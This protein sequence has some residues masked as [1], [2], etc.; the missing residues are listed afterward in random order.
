MNKLLFFEDLLFKIKNPYALIFKKLPR[1]IQQII[2]K[3]IRD[4][5]VK[6]YTMYNKYNLNKEVICNIPKLDVYCGI[7]FNGGWEYLYHKKHWNLNIKDAFFYYH[8]NK[9]YGITILNNLRNKYKN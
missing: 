5:L 9:Q 1:E 3:N 4:T 8:N 7:Y 6:N 2:Y